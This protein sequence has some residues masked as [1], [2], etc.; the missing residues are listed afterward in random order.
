MEFICNTVIIVLCTLVEVKIKPKIFIFLCGI[1][2]FLIKSDRPQQTNHKHLAM[3]KEAMFILNISFLTLAEITFWK[4]VYKDYKEITRLCGYSITTLK[5]FVR[6]DMGG[7]TK[8]MWTKQK[9]QW[10]WKPETSLPVQIHTCI[11]MKTHLTVSINRFRLAL[12][13][14]SSDKCKQLMSHIWIFIYKRKN[15]TECYTIRRLKRTWKLEFKFMGSSLYLQSLLCFL[16]FL[17]FSLL[18]FFAD[19]PSLYC[20]LSRSTHYCCLMC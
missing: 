2:F 7:T 4:G 14:L 6:W 8:E 15:T 19:L 16:S 10:F 3:N 5:L 11:F 18:I 20:A 17:T 9:R 1:F 12:W 13:A